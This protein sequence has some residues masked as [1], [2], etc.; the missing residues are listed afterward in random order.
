M[1]SKDAG[2][3][4]AFRIKFGRNDWLGSGY[5]IQRMPLHN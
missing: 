4:I 5:V 2:K 3:A 1:A